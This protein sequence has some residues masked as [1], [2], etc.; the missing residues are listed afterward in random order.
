MKSNNYIFCIVALHLLLY[1][2]YSYC[3]RI[4]NF[5]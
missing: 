5:N 1:I 3:F 2:Q 4:V